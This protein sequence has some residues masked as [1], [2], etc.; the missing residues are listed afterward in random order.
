MV[1]GMDD[2]EWPKPN[3]EELPDMYAEIDDLLDRAEEAIRENFDV[4]KRGG[5]EVVVFANATVDDI[6]DAMW[7]ETEAIVP[8]FQKISG[9]PNREY[10]ALYNEPS[11]GNRLRDYKTDFRDRENAQDFAAAMKD[12]LPDELYLET[13]LY[14]FAK[15]WENDQ[16]RFARMSFEEDV[17][18]FLVENG[19][20]ARKDESLPGKPDIVIPRERPFE[21]VGEVRVMK[22]ED[23][24]KRIKNFRD[25]AREAAENFPDSK[26][27]IVANMP[28]Y[29]IDGMREERRTEI[30]DRPEIDAVF[31]RDELEDILDQLEDWGVTRQA[32]LS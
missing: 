26:F 22:P 3:I 4:Q 10:R 17:I 30:G 19:Y 5:G 31:F 29:A 18:E 6:L 13:V 15:M 25:E 2:F 27:I 7:D 23:I 32:T 11:I 12:H 9:L 24:R 28:P 1:P 16:R 20:P 14:T 21:V 8:L